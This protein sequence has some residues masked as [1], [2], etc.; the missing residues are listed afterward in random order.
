[1]SLRS[2]TIAVA[3]LTLVIHASTSCAAEHFGLGRTAAP[4]E[5]TAW[6]IDVR[7][8]DGKGLPP[9]Q[10]SVADGRS[11]FAETCAACHGE[12]GQGGLADVLV[13]GQGTLNTAKPVKTIGSFW[14]YAP[15]LFDYIHRAMPYN[16]PQSLTADQ[17]YALTA[18][19]LFLN[20]ILPDN[21]TLDA[22]SLAKIEMPNRGGFTS[23]PRPDIPRN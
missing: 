21:T 15:T 5:I 13:G 3:T 10:G 14:P 23:D 11:L 16:A 1:M 8:D 6:D 7:G 9:G 4:T 12:K 2:F 22:A 20:G 17:V 19:L 18:Y